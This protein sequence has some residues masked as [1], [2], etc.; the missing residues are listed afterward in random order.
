MNRALASRI[1]GY[2]LAVLVA[3]GVV[4]ALRMNRAYVDGDRLEFS[5]SDLEGNI[6]D[7]DHADLQGKVLMVNLWGTWCPPCRA[8]LPHLIRLQKMYEERG[9]EIVAIEFPSLMRDSEEER[10][11]ILANFVEEVGINYMVLLGGHASD[12][13]ADLPTLMNADVFPTNIFVGRDG[14]VHSIRSGFYEGDVPM[15]ESLIESL[16]EAD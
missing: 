5:L 6:V 2:T 9:F 8:E 7:Q 14:T 13:G 12:V 4:F 3:V 1:V 10:R 15:Y 16:L 11:E